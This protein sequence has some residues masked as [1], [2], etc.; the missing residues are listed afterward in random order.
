ME[1]FQL[2]YFMLVAKYENFSRAAD[3]LFIS[4]PSVSKA[5]G[6]LEE[7]M[8]VRLF[9]RNGKKIHLT[10]A[11]KTLQ[12]RLKGVMAVLDG[13]R[14]ELQVA[15]GHTQST[16]VFYVRAA[17]SL[18][19][20]LL[21][22]FKTSHPLVNF[23]LIQK[24]RSAKYDLCMMSTLPNVTPNNALLVLNEEIKLAVPASSPLALKDSVDL[25]ML[26]EESLM[27]LNED[28]SLRHIT[29]HFFEQCGF[30]PEISFESDNPYTIRELVAAGLGACMWP[31]VSWGRVGSDMAKLLHI[32]NPICRRNIYISWPESGI[33]S[34][35]AALFLDFVK[36]YFKQLI[37]LSSNR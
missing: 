7:E 13:L 31:E 25:S 18:L 12:D 35:E 11:G 20:N 37:Q 32:T 21:S 26:K 9:E 28:H 34:P 1:L 17:S 24:D 3:E 5:V 27:M 33:T 30:E 14:S 36:N 8:G 15:A 10:N 19:P 4:Q 2:R 6:L 16:I 29:T 22:T 23:Q